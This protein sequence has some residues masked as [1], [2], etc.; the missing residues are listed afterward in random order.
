M[1][2]ELDLPLGVVTSINGSVR[3][4]RRGGRHGEPR[5]HDADGPP[6]RRGDGGRRAGAVRRAARA[7]VPHLV[8]T[9]GHAGS[10]Q[11]LDERRPR[12]LPLQPTSAPRPTR[13]ATPAPPTCS[14]SS[15]ASAAPRAALHGRGSTSARRPRRAPRVG[16]RAGSAPSRATGLPVHRMPSGAGHDAMKLH[17]MMPQ[18]MLFMRGGTPASA[19]TRSRRSA[20]TT[21]SCACARSRTCSNNRHGSPDPR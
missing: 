4:R 16:R 19:T 14:P 11:R 1:L 3:L 10:A 20:T 18:A 5:R 21:P 13:C 17:E 7:A 6:P 8:G 2:N 9:G 15:S 12:P